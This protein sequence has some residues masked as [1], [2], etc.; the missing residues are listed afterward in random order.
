MAKL[1]FP[2][3][4]RKNTKKRHNK[5]IVVRGVVPS[6]TWVGLLVV[7]KCM[8]HIHRQGMDVVTSRS[9]QFGRVAC[10]LP[11]VCLCHFTLLAVYKM[12]LVHARS[13]KVM[14]VGLEAF[15]SCEQ[16]YAFVTGSLFERFRSRKYHGFGCLGCYVPRL[17]VPS[18][19]TWHACADRT[20]D[21]AWPP[22]SKYL[23]A[24]RKC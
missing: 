19:I 11:R 5:F 12:I 8:S 21:V 1:C 16:V 15:S 20:E 14:R 2:C 10:H 4:E 24:L 17:G 6:T 7:S 22:N 9:F 3:D 18:V 23:P 13:N